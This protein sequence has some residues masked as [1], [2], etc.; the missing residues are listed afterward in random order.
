MDEKINRLM[1]LMYQWMNE[2]MDGCKDAMIDRFGG[3]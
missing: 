2:W 1:Y 3:G